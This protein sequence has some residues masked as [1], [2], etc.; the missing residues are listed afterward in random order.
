[1]AVDADG[2]RA[3]ARRNRDQIL[4]AAKEL[5]AEQGVAVPMEEIARRASVGVGTLYRRFRDRDELLRAVL[6]DVIQRVVVEAR[7]A[8]RT[9]PT[10]WRALERILRQSAQFRVVMRVIRRSAEVQS[11]RLGD[12]PEIA[13]LRNEAY[14]VVDQ[15]VAAAHEEGSL[16]A[17]V[18]TT[19]VIVMFSSAM[20]Q[21]LALRDE[22]VTLVADR[23]LAIMLDGLR[24][25]HPGEPLP[26]RP[27]T[28]ADLEIDLPR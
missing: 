20:H 15:V 27:L 12:N 23:A 24:A 2:L 28:R 3:D 5:F 25:G 7:E 21:G 18:G 17:D 14:D 6:E 4:A 9:E 8:Y 19:D 1:M 11:M 22:L 13:R 16:R 10:A 26:G